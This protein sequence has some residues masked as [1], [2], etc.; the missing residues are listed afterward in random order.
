MQKHREKHHRPQPCRNQESRRDRHAIKKRMNRHPHQ[1]A[2][3]RVLVA[4]LLEMRLLTKMKMWRQ[5]MFKQVH[6]EVANQ[7]IQQRALA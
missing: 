4:H 2:R 3:L 7:D 1:H 6:Q 5:R